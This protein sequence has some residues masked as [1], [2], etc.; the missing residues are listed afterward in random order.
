LRVITQAMASNGEDIIAFTAYATGLTSVPEI[1][2]IDFEEVFLPFITSVAWDSSALPDL[3]ITWD[4]DGPMMGADVAMILAS[5]RQDEVSV[6]WY[7][8]APPDTASPFDF[9]DLPEDYSSI[10]PGSA[11]SILDDVIIVYS[12]LPGIEEY[13]AARLVGME[14]AVE[15]IYE[16]PAGETMRVT[17]GKSAE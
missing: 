12:D 10:L 13:E 11:E 9:P 17:A 6:E 8:F 16:V 4:M 3:G 14:D 2:S 5:W 7:V 15:G 1:V